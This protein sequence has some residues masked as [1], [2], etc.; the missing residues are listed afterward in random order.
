MYKKLGDVLVEG[1]VLNQEQVRTILERQRRDHRPFGLLCEEMFGVPS[2]AVEEAWA[3]Q[4][5]TI[6]RT[7]DPAVEAFDTEASS[8]VTRRQAWQFRFLPIRFEDGILMAATT[9]ANVR[10]ALRFA[11]SAIP[12]PV[13]LVI[14]E[15]LAL[16]VSLCRRYPL[17]GMRAESLCEEAYVSDALRT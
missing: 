13:Y 11:N 3:R 9:T 2:S 14:A 8:L 17:A 16:G 12:A 6:T 10:R 5:A 15:P 1:G 4:Y 7:V